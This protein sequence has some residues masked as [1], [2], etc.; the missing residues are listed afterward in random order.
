MA[1]EEVGFTAR[2]RKGG[3]ML[4]EERARVNAHRAVVA[5]VVPAFLWERGVGSAFEGVVEVYAGS[6]SQVSWAGALDPGESW[7]FRRVRWGGAGKG[8]LR[9]R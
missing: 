9:R 8:F 5:S 7:V 4:E 1:W 2:R 3:G 6:H